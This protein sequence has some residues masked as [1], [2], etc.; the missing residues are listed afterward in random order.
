MREKIWT[1]IGGIGMTLLLAGGCA[2][3][4]ESLILPALMVLTGAGMLCGSAKVLEK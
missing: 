3:D 2:M 1:I 4:S